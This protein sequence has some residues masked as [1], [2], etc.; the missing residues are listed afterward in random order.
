MLR[1][2]NRIMQFFIIVSMITFFSGCGNQ[3]ISSGS[4]LTSPDGKLKTDIYVY[5]SGKL[6]YNLEKGG[7]KVLTD[8]GM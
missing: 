2:T 7:T 5:R 6:V 3:L 8:S 1:A 4:K